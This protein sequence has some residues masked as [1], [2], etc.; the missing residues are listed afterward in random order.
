MHETIEDYWLEEFGPDRSFLQGLIQVATGY[1]KW[2]LSVPG[3]AVRLM[4]NGLERLEAYPAVH[5]GIDL[6]LFIAEVRRQLAELEATQRSRAA[7]PPLNPPRITI[8]K[9]EAG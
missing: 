9:P 8:R 6:G 7:L 3:G 5:A 2:E 1:Y 4:K